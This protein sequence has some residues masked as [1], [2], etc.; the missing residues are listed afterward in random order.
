[1]IELGLSLNKINSSADSINVLHP[2]ENL[3]IANNLD[4]KNLEQLLFKNSFS[5]SARA[6]IIAAIT[7]IFGLPMSQ[8]NAF[9]AAMYV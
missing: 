1:M 4:G 2:F 9:F 8:I 3:K 7:T 6:I 5:G